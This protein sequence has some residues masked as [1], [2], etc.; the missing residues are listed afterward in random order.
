MTVQYYP[1][2]DVDRVGLQHCDRALMTIEG[3]NER[4]QYAMVA[5]RRRL[6][7]AQRTVQF[8]WTQW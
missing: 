3:N 8:E 6:T 7:S 4:K 5:F 1:N 2:I